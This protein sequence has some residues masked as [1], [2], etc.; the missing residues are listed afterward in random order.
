ML[1]KQTGKSHTQQTRTSLL[2]IMTAGN[3]DDGKSTLIGR[4][5]LDSGSLPEDVISSLQCLKKNENEH[6]NLAFVTDGL[7]AER[8]QGI[9]IDVAYRYFSTSKR[10]F[11]IADTPGHAEFTRNMITAASVSDA[12][13]I[14]LDVVKGISLQTR[15][16]VAIAA[17]MGIKNIIVCINKM[18]LVQYQKNVFEKVVVNF[19]NSISNKF[20]NTHFH[21]IPISALTGE[22][23]IHSSPALSWFKGPTLMETLEGLTSDN[24]E[25]S[26]LAGRFPVQYVINAVNAENTTYR[27]YAGRVA[28]GKFTKNQS[29]KLMPAGIKSSIKKI[30]LR[31]AEFDVASAGMSVN[32]TLTD[33]LEVSRGNILCSEEDLPTLTRTFKAKICW[34]SSLPLLRHQKFILRHTTSETRCEII[35]IKN[36]LNLESF[37]SEESTSSLEMNDIGEIIIKTEEQIVADVYSKIKETGC[38]ILIDERTNSTVAG[39]TITEFC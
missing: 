21:F 10:K 3:V 25:E 32:I 7:K 29:I 1:T 16:H 14:L 36:K 26:I 12:A 39:G 37:S 20:C 38:F 6:F 5:L 8:Q 33:D 18:D 19:K 9:T 4:L 27:A 13:I 17:L 31:G 34:M 23:V 30:E 35:D 24:E 2:R 11:I 28:A 22:N 15:R